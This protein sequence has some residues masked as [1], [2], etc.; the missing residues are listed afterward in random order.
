MTRCPCPPLCLEA[1]RGSEKLRGRATAGSWSLPRGGSGPGVG[2][3]G[4][5]GV[6]ARPGR[7]LRL[8]PQRGG[9]RNCSDEG[10]Q[11]G[12]AGC[13][14]S[15]MGEVRPQSGM[16]ERRKLDRGR[17]CALA[18]SRGFVSGA[19]WS[20][21]RRL[22]GLGGDPAGGRRLWGLEWGPGGQESRGPHGGESPEL[23]P[24]GGGRRE[25]PGR[26]GGRRADRQAV[27]SWGEEASGSGSHGAMSLSRD[28]GGG[29]GLRRK[30]LSL[31][32]LG[33]VLGRRCGR[34]GEGHRGLTR[35]LGQLRGSLTPCQWSRGK[36][37]G[38]DGW[39]MDDG[40]WMDG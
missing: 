20:L 10:W 19:G 25:R 30:M 9:R 28:T 34:C 24:D 27:G 18:T 15:D 29:A 4:G 3:P 26:G 7:T 17:P 37:G 36:E 12:R 5:G 6:G 31:G 1:L 11:W 13:D 16:R 40:R 32:V 38:R 21:G 14:S 2:L 33:R 22:H 8:S 35:G 23:R 39:W